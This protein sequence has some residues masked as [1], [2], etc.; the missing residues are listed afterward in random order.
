MSCGVRGATAVRR[1][2]LAEIA[3]YGR[4][5][6]AHPQDGHSNIESRRSF[7][8]AQAHF[9]SPTQIRWNIE[10]LILLQNWFQFAMCSSEASILCSSFAR[11]V[12]DLQLSCQKI[13]LRKA[14]IRICFADGRSCAYSLK[15]RSILGK[16][17]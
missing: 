17:N 13:H 5:C 7:S 1:T 12:P 15:E 16:R 8:T 6:F 3:A 14:V 11:N 10:K 9:A 2:R 4:Q